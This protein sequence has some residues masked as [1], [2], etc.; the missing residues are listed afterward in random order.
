MNVSKPLTHHISNFFREELRE[1]R[2]LSK[3]TY[4]C[5]QTSLRFLASFVQKRLQKKLLEIH[6]DEL[7]YELIRNWML[8]EKKNRNWS[9][10]T[11]NRHLAAIRSFLN[12]LATTNIRYLDLASRVGLIKSQSQKGKHQRQPDYLTL[13]E[14]ETKLESIGS[15]RVGNFRDKVMFQLLFFTGARV[16]E[17]TNI[18]VQDLVW[19]KPRE[20][21]IYLFGKNRK[22][23]TVLLKEKTTLKNLRKY[24]DY[25]VKRG[26]DSEYLFP[27]KRGERMSEENVRRIT[28]KHYGDIENKHITPHSFRH[29]AAMN[30]LERGMDIFDVSILLG[31][32]D[33]A[34]TKRYLRA[35]MKLKRDALEAA[36]QDRKISHVFKTKYNSN[37]EF[38]ESLN[39]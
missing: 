37:E 16:A 23:R 15:Y 28:R 6:T 26:L 32:E 22:E 17:L 21:T 36:G 8:H 7:T 35:T 29:S 38:W 18:R 24:L 5:Y 12:Y 13:E 11:W 9:R 20:L 34:T 4:R 10:S 31:H 27:N 19:I 2:E 3:H 39:A 33:I 25:L 14:F 1:A 30:W